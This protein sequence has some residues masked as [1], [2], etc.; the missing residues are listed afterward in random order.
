MHPEH[1]EITEVDVTF[2]LAIITAE[3]RRWPRK[4]LIDLSR[5]RYGGPVQLDVHVVY[6]ALGIDPPET[7]AQADLSV[8]ARPRESGKRRDAQG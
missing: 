2:V 5:H 3:V 1:A 8:V 4:T 6:K 7:D